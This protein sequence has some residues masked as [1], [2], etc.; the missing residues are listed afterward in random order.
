MAELTEDN[1]RVLI[2]SQ[3]N[4]KVAYRANC[5]IRHKELEDNLREMKNRVNKLDGKIWAIL[6]LLVGNMMGGLLFFF[7]RLS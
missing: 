1:V 3:M 2:H 6:M 7:L 4:S 5:E